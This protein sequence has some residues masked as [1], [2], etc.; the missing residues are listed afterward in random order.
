MPLVQ[1]GRDGGI[2]GQAAGWLLQLAHSSLPR[3]PAHMLRSEIWLMAMASAH[4]ASQ[5][6]PTELIV[7]SASTAQASA[8]DQRAFTSLSHWDRPSR[9][10]CDGVWQ[11]PQQVS[12][13]V[14]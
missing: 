12:G 13:S 8:D 6:D 2:G 5:R 9:H 7:Q 14:G 10:C 11:V 4:V 3:S 1:A